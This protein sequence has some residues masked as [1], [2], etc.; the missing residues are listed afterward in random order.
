M[1]RSIEDDSI[2]PKKGL[3]RAY[4]KLGGNLLKKINDRTT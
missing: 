1:F 3:I 4:N 2:P